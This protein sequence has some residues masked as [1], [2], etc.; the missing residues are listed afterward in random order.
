MSWLNTR[1]ETIVLKI[2]QLDTLCL[3]NKIFL[4][5]LNLVF[6]KRSLKSE[7]IIVIGAFNLTHAYYDLADIVA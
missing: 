4:Q 1:F 5:N 7:N 2:T 3:Y 6:K